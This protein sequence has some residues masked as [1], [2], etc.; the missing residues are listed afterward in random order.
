[1]RFGYFYRLSW[2]RRAGLLFV[3]LAAIVLAG[4]TQAASSPTRLPTSTPTPTLA[5]SPTPVSQV[6]LEEVVLPTPD[7][8]RLA[9]LSSWLSLVPGDFTAAVFVDVEAVTSNAQLQST[10]DME[11]LGVPAIVPLGVTNLLDMVGVASG[12]EGHGS[13]AVLDGSIDVGSLLQLAGGFGISVGQ[14]K[15]ELYRDHRLWNIDVFG[16]SLAVGEVDP[17]TVVLSSGSSS[18]GVSALD[19]VQSSLDS[20]DGLTS[21]LL[22]SPDNQTL[23]NNLPSGFTMTLLAR[24]GD[25]TDL[26]AVMDL[27]N[28]TGAAVSA[29]SL[30]VDRV[31][32]YGL[33]AFEDATLAAG[34]LRLALEHIEAGGGLPFAKVEAGQVGELIWSRSTV[35]PGQVAQ[36]LKAFSSQN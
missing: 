27:P 34:A 5:P 6:N 13:L 4:C 30:G 1:M 28:C 21:T 32:F 3:L 29:Q 24:C 7:P 16:L 17:A 33:V 12:P 22:D 23:L 31:V 36:A 2:S 10:F 9:K 25:F 20:A 18:S 35:E 19:L 8:D 15:P 11:S 14:P 26:A